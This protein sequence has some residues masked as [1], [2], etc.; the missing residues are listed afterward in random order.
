MFE[1]AFLICAHQQITD[2]QN[3]NWY[4]FADDAKPKKI[5]IDLLLPF[6]RGCLRAISEK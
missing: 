1:K 3:A 6:A 2:D 4:A 5:G